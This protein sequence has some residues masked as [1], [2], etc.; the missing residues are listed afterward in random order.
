MKIRAFL[1]F[2]NLGTVLACDGGSGVSR[3]GLESNAELSRVRDSYSSQSS[4]SSTDTT[5]EDTTGSSDPSV[6]YGTYGTKDC[7]IMGNRKAGD[8]CGYDFCGTSDNLTVKALMNYLKTNN[9]VDPSNCQNADVIKILTSLTSLDLHGQN[10][11]DIAPLL[12]M[13]KLQTLNLANNSLTSDLSYLRLMTNLVTLDVSNNQLTSL[14]GISAAN[15]LK[16]IYASNNKLIDISALGPCKN[17]EIADLG[18]NQIKSI[19]FL[20]DRQVT[21]N[22]ADNPGVL[23]EADNPAGPLNT[24]GS[25]KQST[26]GEILN[27]VAGSTTCVWNGATVSLG[28]I[29]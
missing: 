23:T 17:L 24:N 2:L 18:N 10:L 1:I 4:T 5:Q 12:M 19:V 14:A 28:K 21:I 29:P 13:T 15:G 20:T 9:N 22:V 3:S 16:S 26:G 11:T 25:C 6:E 27:D 7:S 8:I